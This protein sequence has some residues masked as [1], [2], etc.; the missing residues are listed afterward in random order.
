MT[1]RVLIAEV[2]QETSTFNPMPTIY[3]EFRRYTD[4]EILLAYRGTKTELA[5][6]FEVFDEDGRI[7][8][9]PTVAADCVSGG[10]IATACLDRLLGEMEQSVREQ[11]DIDA[12]YICLHGAMAGAEEGDPEG[13]LLKNLREILGDIPLDRSALRSDRP[14]DRKRRC[15]HSLPHVPAHRPLPDRPASRA[16]STRSAWRKIKAGGCSS[17]I[18]HARPR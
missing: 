5:G 18:T 8:L 14:H 4:E 17:R 7:E 3:D 6:A 2:K 1:W 10:P 13:R 16:K 11:P 12:A 15:H 9:V